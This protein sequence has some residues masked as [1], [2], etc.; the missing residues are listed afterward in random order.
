MAIP[1][2]GSVSRP[3]KKKAKALLPIGKKISTSMPAAEP[4]K[5]PVLAS[6]KAKTHQKPNKAVQKDQPCQGN[7]LKKPDKTS[8]KQMPLA[9]K[10]SYPYINNTTPLSAVEAQ[11]AIKSLKKNGKSQMG[12]CYALAVRKGFEVLG[13][14]SFKECLE[15]RNVGIGYD[16][17]HKLKTAGEIH[18]VVCPKIPMGTISEGVLRPLHKYS[19]DDKKLIWKRAVIKCE[20]KSRKVTKKIIEEIIKT[21]EFEKESTRTKAPIDIEISQALTSALQKSACDLIKNHNLIKG[22][23]PVTKPNFNK[24][25]GLLFNEV[26]SYVSDRYEKLHD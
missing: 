11:E 22:K 19:D 15:K 20:K 13:H 16:Y 24:A 2:R 23:V 6:R 25:L 17:A 21:G 1:K 14:K 5:K 26:R 10:G 8:E 9:E 7:I 4:I 18:M 12:I 3:I